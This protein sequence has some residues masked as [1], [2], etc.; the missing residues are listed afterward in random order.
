MKQLNPKQGAEII[1]NDILLNANKRVNEYVNK[2]NQVVKKY[3]KEDM[4]KY[5]F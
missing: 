5:T 4:S 2:M 3:K 1:A